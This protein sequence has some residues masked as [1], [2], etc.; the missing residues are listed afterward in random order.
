MR[1]TRQKEQLQK[2]FDLIDTFFNAEEFYQQLKD[3]SIGIATV[4]RFLNQKEERN[5]LYAY[6]CDRRKVYSKDQKTHCHFTCE[7]TG[8]VIH[9]EIK[10]LDFLKD[11]IPGKIRSLQLE[12]KGVCNDCVKEN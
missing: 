10:S 7:K 3:K 6:V 8:Q 2:A 12:V 11:K 1:K 5:E 4:Y 9:F